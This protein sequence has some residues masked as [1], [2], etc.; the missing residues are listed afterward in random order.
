VRNRPG[1]LR[2]DIAA[3]REFLVPRCLPY[4]R[5]LE[6]IE[7]E[8]DR[9]LEARLAD[10]WRGRQFG[11]FYE[12][13][14]LLLG[15]LRLEAL[16]SGV[17]HPLWRAVASPDPDPGAVN[18]DALR[19]ALAPATIWSTLATRHLQTNEPT[20]AVAWL[21]PARLA[22]DTAG[23]R[24]L[25]IVD[26]GA[27]AG[28]NLVAD[29][30]PPIWQRADGTPLDVRPAGP[31]VWRAGFDLRPLDVTIADDALWLRACVW[32]GEGHR[33]ARLQEAIDAFR[34]LQHHPN[35]PV[36]RRA[37]AA[38]VP[39]MLAHDDDGTLTIAYQTVVR[40]Y[41][42]ASEWE[43]YQ[44]GMQD[45]L[46]SR[47]RG[48]AIWA[49]LEVAGTVR[50]GGPAAALA[51]HMRSAADLVTFVLAECDPHPQRLT[52]NGRAIADFVAALRT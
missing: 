16:R 22:A 36:V 30:L 24:P 46:R 42:P 3:Q 10:V 23:N 27:S 32:P 20:R 6:L 52:C 13:P 4:A 17:R 50:N 45:W 25:A 39:P 26:I 1:T 35:P 8:L 37:R 12:R 34:R 2:E 33:E 18:H 11:A 43:T 31:V 51:V 41:L 5:M 21:W 40:D 19:D 44:T 48:S 28:L 47:P 7:P 29:Q 9:G 38:D 14:L 49:E 15:A